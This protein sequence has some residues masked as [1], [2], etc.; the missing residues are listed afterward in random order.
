MLT[1]SEPAL[2]AESPA[3]AGLGMIGVAAHLPVH[4]VSTGVRELTI[5]LTMYDLFG[6]SDNGGAE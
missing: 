5:T 6:W 2:A 3:V 1:Y 4:R